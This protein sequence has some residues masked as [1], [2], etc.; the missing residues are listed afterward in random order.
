MIVNS[1]VN[2]FASLEQETPRL[3]NG[4]SDLGEFPG[5]VPHTK[6]H[7]FDGRLLIVGFGS[8]GG[9]ACISALPFPCPSLRSLS[10]SLPPH[11]ICI[12]TI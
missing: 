9:G 8:I 2:P 3:P 12:P 4:N 10:S 5:S 1:L 7:K 11:P 6:F